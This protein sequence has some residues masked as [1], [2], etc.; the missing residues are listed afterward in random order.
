MDDISKIHPLEDKKK[1]EGILLKILHLGKNDQFKPK[2]EVP[3]KINP[4][5][6]Y[7]FKDLVRGDIELSEYNFN[8]AAVDIITSIN[9]YVS[10]DD[11]LK[12]GMYRFGDLVNKCNLYFFLNYTKTSKIQISKIKSQ[13][14]ATRLFIS[15]QVMETLRW[16]T[17]KSTFIQFLE[18]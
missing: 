18:M 14:R 3:P 7:K 9:G 10:M 12:Y 17:L 16:T 6:F 15:V 5:E 2:F 4:D 13:M 11:R 1:V 8:T